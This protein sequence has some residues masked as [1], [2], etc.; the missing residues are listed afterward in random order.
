MKA[1]FWA[2][3]SVRL[4]QSA[5]N[6]KVPGSSPGGPTKKSLTSKGSN[7]MENSAPFQ[8]F[9]DLIKFDQQIIASHKK[10]ATLKKEI[11]Q[12][13]NQKQDLA[14]SLETTKKDLIS[15]EKEVHL[16][17][18]RMSELNE[19][20]E[21]KKKLLQET[22]DEKTYHAIKREIENIKRSQNVYENELVHS[23]NKLEQLKKEDENIK[24]NINI[25]LAEFDNLIADKNKELENLASEIK[26][27]SEQRKDKTKDI[28]QEWLDKYN[29]MYLQVSNPVVPVIGQSC[30]A[31]FHDVT[32]QDYLDL[33]KRKLLQCKGC[34]RL[35][36]AEG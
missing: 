14:N 13:Q 15:A 31:C 33:K 29:V 17:E 23:W 16:Q 35:L 5:H 12:L 8:K 4:E 11:E 24:N 7:K 22:S 19:R 32:R 10:I 36:Y 1:F 26:L 18:L 30:S 27:H 3:S 2:H 6:R 9:I 34:F 25:K 21:N 28:P 20:E